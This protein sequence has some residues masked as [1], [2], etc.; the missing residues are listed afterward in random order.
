MHFIKHLRNIHIKSIFQ[1]KHVL[2]QA[3]CLQTDVSSKPKR[4]KYPT[5]YDPYGPR[6]PPSEK[7]TQLAEQI[8]TLTSEE[9]AQIGPAL[10]ELLK[11][12]KLEKIST[13]GLDLGGAAGGATTA[14]EEKVAEKTAFDVKLEKFDATSK[15]KVIK[16]VRALTSLG[17][18]EAKE[19][20]EKAPV[21]LK[22][23]LTKE[24]AEGMIE[25]IKAAGG[26]AVM[27]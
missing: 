21:V 24:E 5:A 1:E 19:L 26:S 22:Q 10:R 27:E 4:Y 12:P 15:L 8:I 3:R 13:E 17:L 16:E 14:A 18:K 11:H 2:F 7:V 20:V 6:P 23:G 25:K 9:R